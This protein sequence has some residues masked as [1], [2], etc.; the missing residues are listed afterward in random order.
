MPR[1]TKGSSRGRGARAP[2][3][4][5]RKEACVQEN[6]WDPCTEVRAPEGGFGGDLD[7]SG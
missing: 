5:S 6:G 2:K 4:R 3:P 7:K 1:G